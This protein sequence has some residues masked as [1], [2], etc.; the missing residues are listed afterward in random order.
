M[1]QRLRNSRNP[2]PFYGLFRQRRTLENLNPRSPKR[3]DNGIDGD[4][5]SRLYMYRFHGP[6]LFGAQHRF[7]FHR[8]DDAKWFT[9][10]DLLSGNNF[11]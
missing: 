6:I 2:K 3:H 1:S 10:F 4:R 9:C 8:F 11:D 7:H 5:G